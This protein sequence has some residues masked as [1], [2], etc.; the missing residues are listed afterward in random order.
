MEREEQRG[1]YGTARATLGEPS[2]GKGLDGNS[3]HYE[4]DNVGNRTTESDCKG[5]DLAT[6][7]LVRTVTRRYDALGR[8]QSVS[9]LQ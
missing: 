2:H 3:E 4:L 8:L 1:S 9:G 6:R 7:T 5:T